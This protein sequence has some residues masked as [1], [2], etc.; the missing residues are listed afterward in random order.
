[1]IASMT[2]FAR[3]E[4]SGDWGRAIWEIRTVNHRYLEIGIR[5]PDDLR[6]LESK[7]RE[8]I[9]ARLQRGKVDCNLRYEPDENTLGDIT[10]NRRMAETLIATA[11][12]LTLAGPVTINTMDIL[13]WPG[14]LNK[15][16]PDAE[17]IG[18]PLL[19]ML[20][21]AID[22][23]LETR[24]REGEKLAGLVL[25]RCNA[26]T[27]CITATRAKLPGIMAAI[28]ERIL[29]RAQELATNIDKD[30][31]EQEMVI[32]AQKLDV[33]EELDRL[34]AH[35]GEVRRILGTED[36]KGRRLDF[37]MQ[38]MNREAN[39]LGSKAGSIDV[40][41]AS[42]ELKVLIEQMR[43]QIQNIE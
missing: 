4:D 23:I 20:D 26:A 10:I 35:I 38:E 24:H 9:S 33:A 32:L 21:A 15:E 14:V 6:M 7:I 12:S 34:E 1:M 18:G 39:T 42:V 28:R 11:E 17:A 37:L 13:R 22:I 16:S 30:R 8:R 5:I 31:L 25:E 40:S 29:S 41:N 3:L 27:Q 2:A 43:E 36:A 19:L